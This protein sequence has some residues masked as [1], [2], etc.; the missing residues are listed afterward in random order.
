MLI[1]PALDKQADAWG[2]GQ[3]GL[4]EAPRPVRPYPNGENID[5]VP[6][7]VNLGRKEL[8]CLTSSKE[9]KSDTSS[10]EAKSDTSSREANSEAEDRNPGSRK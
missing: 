10:K 2:S 3:P 9:A 1:S 6:A 4:L 8:M 7:L 5:S